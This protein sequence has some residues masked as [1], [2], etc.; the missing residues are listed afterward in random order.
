MAGGDEKVLSI[1]HIIIRLHSRTWIKRIIYL[2][3]RPLFAISFF[4]SRRPFLLVFVVDDCR[5][6]ACASQIFHQSSKTPLSR[7]SSAVGREKRR[8]PVRKK[9]S[10]W[11]RRLEKTLILLPSNYLEQFL[12][13][14]LR[15]EP[16]FLH[17]NEARKMFLLVRN[18]LVCTAHYSRALPISLFR[19][20]SDK[21]H[22][23]END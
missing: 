6:V 10:V 14:L 1:I 19:D 23:W 13:L 7:N 3:F 20:R 4:S 18:V 15:Y 16:L 8:R 5:S 9:S 17:S 2:S 22:F 21:W 12:L 11:R